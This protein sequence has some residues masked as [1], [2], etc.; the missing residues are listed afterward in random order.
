MPC[1]KDD[2]GKRDVK[3]YVPKNCSGY[4]L[5]K[6]KLVGQIGHQTSERTSE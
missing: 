4:L 6:K 2:I 3:I 1:G 5:G